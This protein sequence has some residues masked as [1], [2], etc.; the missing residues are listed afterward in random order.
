M[1]SSLSSS[2]SSSSSPPPPRM[3]A[4]STSR[5]SRRALLAISASLATGAI[6]LSHVDVALA[7]RT[8]VAAKRAFDRYYPRI[9]EGR[10]TL[11][12][13]GNALKE[14][15]MDTAKTLTSK[16]EF[17]IR[18]RRALSIYAGSFSDNYVGKETR[19]L[20]A[21]VQKLFDEV[22]L[23]Q[24]ATS[25]EDALQ[26]YDIAVKAFAVYIKTARLPKDALSGL[27]I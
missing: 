5:T 18:F 7:D 23:L 14:N 9:V 20:M 11:Q 25:K 24:E 1:T 21:C 10:D 2:S 6:S 26:H 16:K 3:S 8:L 4:S 12:Q 19:Q 15:D 22:H 13:V 17:D 27:D